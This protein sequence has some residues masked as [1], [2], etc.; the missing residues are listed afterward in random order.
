M[1]LG[2]I[3]G[4]IIAV[5]MI[6]GGMVA[7]HA[8]GLIPE[9]LINLPSILIVMGGTVGAL[10]VAYPLPDFVNSLKALGKYAKA[11]PVSP[12]ALMAEILELAGIARKE[13][14]LALE[15]RVE[16][17]LFKP[18][19]TAIRMAVDGTDP[20]IIRD[21]LETEAD[22][23]H[24]EAEV[25]VKFWEDLGAIAPTIGILG[26]V[27]GLMKVMGVLDQPEKIGPGISV[28][29]IATVWGVGVANIFGIPIGKRLKRKAGI[30]HHARMMVMI[31]IEGIL[32]GHNPKLIEA[33]LRIFVHSPGGEH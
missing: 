23:E 19:A 30:D 16:T 17:I 9:I 18:L 33:K 20:N 29:F 25:A 31:G 12:E 2:A 7:K 1:D 22:F 27:I 6:M 14:I 21:A 4:P 8:A 28:A 10:M 11:S 3:L 13:S 32:S 5:G 26:A 24:E 15:K